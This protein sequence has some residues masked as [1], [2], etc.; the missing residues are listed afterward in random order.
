LNNEILNVMK[1]FL[2]LTAL[3]V[4]NIGLAQ[5]DT[6]SVEVDFDGFEVE[7]PELEK[8]GITADMSVGEVVFNAPNEIDLVNIYDSYGNEIFSAQGT[9]IEDSKIDVSFLPKGTFYLEVVIGEN[10]GAHKLN[11]K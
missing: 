7:M 10:M 2:L 9:I 8:F 5:D 11:I 4:F 3:L 6:A 1:K